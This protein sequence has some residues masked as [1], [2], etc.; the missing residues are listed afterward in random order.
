MKLILIE[1]E[2]TDRVLLIAEP[3]DTKEELLRAEATLEKLAIKN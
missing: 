1:Q 2:D 3:G